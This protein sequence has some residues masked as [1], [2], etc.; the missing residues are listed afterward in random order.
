MTIYYHYFMSDTKAE[1]RSVQNNFAPFDWSILLD[2]FHKSSESGMAG[3]SPQRRRHDAFRQERDNMQQNETTSSNS[4]VTLERMSMENSELRLQILSCLERALALDR[5]STVQQDVVVRLRS[6]VTSLVMHLPQD[7]QEQALVE[8]NRIA[9]QVDLAPQASVLVW[10]AWTL[11]V[12]A[13]V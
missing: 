2:F 6:F 9:S 8:L 13:I 11:R 3:A 12:V 10:T 7:T 1:L 5:L 4:T